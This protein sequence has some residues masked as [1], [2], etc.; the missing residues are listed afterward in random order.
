MASFIFIGHRPN[1]ALFRG[2]LDLDEQGY[3]KTDAVDAHQRARGVRR[4]RGHGSALP[5]G[6][7]LRRNGRCR[8]DDGGALLA[9]ARGITPLATAPAGS[10]RLP[11]IKWAAFSL[12]HRYAAAY[13]CWCDAARRPPDEHPERTGRAG[14]LVDGLAVQRVAGL[15]HRHA[16]TTAGRAARYPPGGR[17]PGQCTWYRSRSPPGDAPCLGQVLDGHGVGFVLA[18]GAHCRPLQRHRIVGR[19]ED[20]AGRQ[21]QVGRRV[22]R[23]L[24]WRGRRAGG[25]QALTQRDL[26][27]LPLIDDIAG[28]AVV[29]L[30]M[31]SIETL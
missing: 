21:E 22:G 23:R 27:Y 28:Q 29:G 18:Q 5:P 26:Q 17:P 3:I 1:T 7:H 12:D 24:E 11:C 30:E 20:G 6:G 19:G 10:K 13:G 2:Q 4:R 16:R 8:G 9:G 25:W 31:D 14:L 15:A